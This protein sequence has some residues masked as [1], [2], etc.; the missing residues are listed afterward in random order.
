MGG[1]GDVFEFLHVQNEVGM[2]NLRISLGY[3]VRLDMV[4]VRLRRKCLRQS[5]HLLKA[6]LELESFCHIF[7]LETW[8]LG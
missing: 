3:I 4:M 5:P 2:K 6:P 8:V 7:P 1:G